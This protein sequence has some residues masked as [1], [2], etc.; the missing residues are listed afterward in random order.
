MATDWH[1]FKVLAAF[2]TQR[3]ALLSAWS[4]KPA[5]LANVVA[6]DFKE[7]R[8]L[9]AQAD[10]ERWRRKLKIAQTKIRKLRVRVRYYDRRQAAKQ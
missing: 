6:V 7:K 5:R 9:K 3:E 8:A 1:S 2:R 10:L 4:E